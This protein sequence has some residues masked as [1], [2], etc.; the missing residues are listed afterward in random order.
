MLRGLTLLN[1]SHSYWWSGIW[2]GFGFDFCRVWLELVYKYFFNSQ[3]WSWFVFLF[4]ISIALEASHLMLN[5]LRFFKLWYV[6]TYH[7]LCYRHLEPLRH[8]LKYEALNA[9]WYIMLLVQDIQL[10]Y[11]NWDLQNFEKGIWTIR[12]KLYST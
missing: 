11:V 4:N 1:E 2:L 5:L 8:S 10:Y 3:C 12:N 9:W 7:Y 6:G